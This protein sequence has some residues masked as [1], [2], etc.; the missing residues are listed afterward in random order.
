MGGGK[1]LA[2]LKEL[3]YL[4]S[5]SAPIRRGAFTFLQR[6]YATREKSVVTWKDGKSG[7]EKVLF[8]PNTWSKDGSASLG[9]WQPSWDGSRVAY[10][11]KAN[12]S[13]E[14][15]LRVFALELALPWRLGRGDPRFPRAHRQERRRRA[16]V[17]HEHSSG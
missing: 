5:V 8:D 9:G 13:D 15:T 1:L 3:A 17:H 14:A 6:R 16:D 4:D 12:N 11:V 7:E 2:R 10:L